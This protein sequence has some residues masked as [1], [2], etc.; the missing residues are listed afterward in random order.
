VEDLPRTITYKQFKKT[1]LYIIDD[2]REKHKMSELKIVKSG[3]VRGYP[4]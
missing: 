3:Y 1:L 4:K 2:F